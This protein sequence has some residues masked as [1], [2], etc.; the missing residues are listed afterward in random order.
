MATRRRKTSSPS[1]AKSEEPAGLSWQQPPSKPRKQMRRV[2][3]TVSQPTPSG[4][5][6]RPATA[7]QKPRLRLGGSWQTYVR[8]TFVS[9][10]VFGCLVGFWAL[11][12]LPQLTVTPGSTQIGGSQRISAEEVFAA[13]QLEG[14]NIMLIIFL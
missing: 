13:S 12:R 2:Q 9:L 5:P 14:H 11:L 1:K 6:P 3:T 8:I 7:R 10:V 4:T